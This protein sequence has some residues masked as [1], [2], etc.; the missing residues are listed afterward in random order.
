MKRLNL[1]ILTFEFQP[2][3][4]FFNRKLIPKHSKNIYFLESDDHADYKIM[5][6][7]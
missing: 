1:E 3:V 4:D 5:F 2:E 7:F 6:C